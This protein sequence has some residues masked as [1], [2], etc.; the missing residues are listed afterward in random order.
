MLMHAEGAEDRVR[1]TDRS[2]ETA[3]ILC[4]GRGE[5]TLIGIHRIAT[6]GR[7]TTLLWLVVSR[8]WRRRC[9]GR[10]LVTTATAG[11][12]WRCRLGALGL[13]AAASLLTATLELGGTALGCEDLGLYLRLDL[14]V[15][16]L[17]SLLLLREVLC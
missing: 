6:W 15:Q 5:R 13:T 9:G 10:T 7:C 14:A 17:G 16:I 11:V 2:W 1:A 3:L 12:S 8:R 4:K